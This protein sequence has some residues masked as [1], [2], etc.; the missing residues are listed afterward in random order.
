M[1]LR[2]VPKV[3]R[4]QDLLT[5]ISST[6]ALCSTREEGPVLSVVPR[7]HW[8]EN[9]CLSVNQLSVT[10]IIGDDFQTPARRVHLS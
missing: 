2:G 8:S 9:I 4:G 3:L 5:L 1:A 6:G 7:I 10:L